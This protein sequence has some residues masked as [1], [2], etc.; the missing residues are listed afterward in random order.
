MH[1]KNTKNNLKFNRINSGKI[2]YEKI[3]KKKKKIFIFNFEN[4]SLKNT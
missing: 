3:K 1:D 4:V 2:N